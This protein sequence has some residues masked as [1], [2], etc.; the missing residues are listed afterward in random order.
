M[1]RIYVSS[2]SP[3]EARYGFSRGVRHGTPDRDRRDCSS[4]G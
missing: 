2:S 4:A 3:Y 1:T